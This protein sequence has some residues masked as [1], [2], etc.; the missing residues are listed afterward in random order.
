MSVKNPPKI[1]YIWRTQSTYSRHLTQSAVV[2]TGAK[3]SGTSPPSGLSTSD[4]VSQ[5]M[6]FVRSIVLSNALSTGR[7]R[8]R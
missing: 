1:A 6:R 4:R 3:C 5:K 7:E 8:M 2:R